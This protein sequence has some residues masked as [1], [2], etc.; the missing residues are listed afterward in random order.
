MKQADIDRQIKAL[1]K[2]KQTILVLWERYQARDKMVNDLENEI[3]NLK[4]KKS[5]KSKKIF[6]KFCGMP[7]KI[8][9]Q[10]SKM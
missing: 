7:F 9:V 3:Y 4:C 8:V 10:Y 2:A 6:L 5:C 1:D